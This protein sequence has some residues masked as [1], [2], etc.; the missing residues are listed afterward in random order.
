MISD[1]HALLGE[2]LIS[3]KCKLP[4]HSTWVWGVGCMGSVIDTQI[5]DAE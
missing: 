4:A 5:T 3:L 1:P 2:I